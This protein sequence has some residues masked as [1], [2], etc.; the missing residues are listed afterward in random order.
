MTVETQTRIAHAV[1][2]GERRHR[3]Y[4]RILV[5]SGLLLSTALSVTTCYALGMVGG[6]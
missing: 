4:T 5:C 6:A 2:D 1:A 3:I